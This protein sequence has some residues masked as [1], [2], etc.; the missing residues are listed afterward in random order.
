MA[1]STRR[2][3][4]HDSV[5]L[6][7]LRSEALERETYQLPIPLCDQILRVPLPHKLTRADADKICRV[8]KALA[9]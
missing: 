2:T 4:E 1:V 8:V 3:F 5:L 6:A 7:M 9:N